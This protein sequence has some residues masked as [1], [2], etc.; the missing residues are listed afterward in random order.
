VGL[1]KLY[2]RLVLLNGLAGTRGS[3]RLELLEDIVD[4]RVN[5]HEHFAEGI[6]KNDPEEIKTAIKTPK[7]IDETPKRASSVITVKA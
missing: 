7:E 6:S 2:D 4:A 1:E 5:G 3:A